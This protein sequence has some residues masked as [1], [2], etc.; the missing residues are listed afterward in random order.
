MKKQDDNYLV[1]LVSLCLVVAFLVFAAG[2]ILYQI[3]WSGVA[4][5]GIFG[6]FFLPLLI[7]PDLKSSRKSS[8]C[9]P[10]GDNY[11]LDPIYKGWLGNVF[12]KK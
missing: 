10:M 7:A 5:F 6:M 11:F 9:R 3:G 2:F 8:R 12:T 4:A 1:F